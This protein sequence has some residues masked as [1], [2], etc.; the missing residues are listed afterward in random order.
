MAQVVT[1]HE[2]DNIKTWFIY[3]TDNGLEHRFSV[4]GEDV[5]SFTNSSPHSAIHRGEVAIKFLDAV[6]QSFIGQF[7]DVTSPTVLK[8]AMTEANNALNE[9]TK[10][11]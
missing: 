5:V 10:T 9:T 11:D 7:S 8:H 4:G 3:N 1:I 2:E 6:V